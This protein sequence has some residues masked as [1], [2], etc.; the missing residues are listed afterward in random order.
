MLILPVLFHVRF[1][2]VFLLIYSNSVAL[3]STVSKG[4]VNVAEL[5]SVCMAYGAANGL[6]PVILKVSP[7]PPSYYLLI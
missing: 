7:P 1:Y 2:K 4:V 5:G 6:N 3:K